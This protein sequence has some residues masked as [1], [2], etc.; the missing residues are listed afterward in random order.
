M[1][2]ALCFA[3]APFLLAQ[4][5]GSVEGIVVDSITK[6]PI[7]GVSV[8]LR[9][10]SKPELTYHGATDENGAFRIVGMPEGE[11]RSRCECEKDGYASG[12]TGPDMPAPP[13]V[14]THIQPLRVYFE[15]I[16]LGKLHGRLVDTE[17]RPVSDATLILAHLAGGAAMEN[18]KPDAEGRFLFEDIHLGTF[19]LQANPGK[20]L[21]PPPVVPGE[22]RTA[23]AITYFPAATRRS[24]AQHIVVRSGADMG[25]FVFRLRT[26]PVHRVRGVVLDEDG[27]PAAGVSVRLIIP[28]Y[29]AG[30][31]GV[32]ARADSKEDGAFE[33]P[34]VNERDWHLAAEVK[35]GNATLRGLASILVQHR[36]VEDVVIPLSA[37]FTM[38][39]PVEWKDA[40]KDGPQR[41]T[42]VLLPDG[43][44]AA[45]EIVGTQLAD[46]TVRIEDVYPGT[47][48]VDAEGYKTQGY[49]LGSLL[50]GE[51]ETLGQ[52]I[53][54]INNSV[55]LRLVFEHGS[56]SVHGTI[57]DCGNA[58]VALWAADTTT[59]SYFHLT[60]CDSAG[61]FEFIDLRPGEYYVAAFAEVV[62][63]YQLQSRDFLRLMMARAAH[64]RLE[65]GSMV[66]IDLKPI[67][68]PE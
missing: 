44:T 67:A 9:N 17:G 31:Y 60:S 10:S 38:N 19:T 2:F 43:D 50:F 54:I 49:H 15:I 6:R 63:R 56:G 22:E 45:E 53:D 58:E 16:P 57:E 59:W 20:S 68:W 3:L 48:R 52:P 29:W 5:T 18:V 21:A 24:E 33:F 25:E 13:L 27:K 51:R 61:H 46:G 42:V 8:T 11:Y 34:A 55:P 36:D 4:S 35:R 65:K 12:K 1:R 30:N 14:V 64:I 32:E 62:D 39:V 23:W 37:P 26:A 40:P 41:A 47:Y 66:S 7:S 28:D